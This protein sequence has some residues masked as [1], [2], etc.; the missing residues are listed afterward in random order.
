MNTRAGL[1]AYFERVP[2]HV[3]TVLDQAY[4]EYVDHPDYAD[5]IEDYVKAGRKAIVLRT[6]SKIFGLAG[7]R[8][9]YGIGPAELVTAIGESG[10]RSTSPRLPRSP[11]SPASVLPARR[12]S[13]NGAGE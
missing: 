11:P 10:A 3:V 8:V 9:G 2:A 13:W 6:F 4:F 12:T 5:G 7:L 1:D